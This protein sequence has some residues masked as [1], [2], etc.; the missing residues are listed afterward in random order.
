MRI[1]LLTTNIK[2]TKMKKAEILTHWNSIEPDQKIKIAEVPYK[3]RGSTYD[4]DG[5]RLTGSKEFID[6]VLSRIKELLSYENH[7]SR[8]QLVYKESHDRKTQAK[9]GSYNCYIQVHERGGQAK[10]INTAF[11]S[12]VSKG[13]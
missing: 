9:L 4:Q 1:K 6:S 5:I 13:Y 2:G 3:H 10:M 8:L 12:I 11:N 7:V